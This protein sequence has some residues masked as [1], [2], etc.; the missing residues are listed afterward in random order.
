M[1][2]KKLKL[3]FQKPTV[4]KIKTRIVEEELKVDKL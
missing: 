2:K 4:K 1:K 3:D